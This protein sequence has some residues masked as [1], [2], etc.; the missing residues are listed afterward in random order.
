MCVP[1]GYKERLASPT[2]LLPSPKRVTRA[3]ASQ[4]K[5]VNFCPRVWEVCPAP[6]TVMKASIPGAA[7]PSLA[8]QQRERGCVSEG[9][10]A[11]HTPAD[12][13]VRPHVA[14]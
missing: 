7:A 3:A 2:H 10:A 14:F 4:R 9:A 11:M 6:R 5:V 12:H 1:A 13:L 8:R